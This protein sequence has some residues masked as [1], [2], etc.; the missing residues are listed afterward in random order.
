MA[1]IKENRTSSVASYVIP[2]AGPTL[3]D[4]KFSFTDAQRRDLRQLLPR[5]L[6][7]PES[8]S[9]VREVE[10]QADLHWRFRARLRLSDS[11]IQ[12]K[13]GDERK[14]IAEA[15]EALKHLRDS[16]DLADYL[17]L[18]VD[19][20]FTM[21]EYWDSVVRAGKL[22]A[23]GVRIH[24]NPS[25]REFENALKQTHMRAEAEGR[26]RLRKIS[27]E[28]LLQAADDSLRKIDQILGR[29]LTVLRTK[30]RKGGRRRDVWRESLV[31]RLVDVYVKYFKHDPVSEENNDFHRLVNVAFDAID[32]PKS[33]RRRLIREALKKRMSTRT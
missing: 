21:E 2:L 22:P 15:R 8:A 16:A 33:G 4:R 28:E 14:R 10:G 19:Q 5:R 11:G 6:A 23:K 29:A 13:L 27:V 17:Q 1:D 32:W 24:A 9:F 7:A 3:P 26:V 20:R 12:A 31:A 18:F 30:R 25:D